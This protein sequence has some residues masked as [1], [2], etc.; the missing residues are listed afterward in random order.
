MSL[1]SLDLP[2]LQPCVD[3]SFWI[4]W[5]P[6]SPINWTLAWLKTF[7]PTIQWAMSFA[8]FHP[9]V[10]SSLEKETHAYGG[11]TATNGFNCKFVSNHTISPKLMKLAQHRIHTAIPKS[12][13]KS[14][15]FHPDHS[16]P[17]QWCLQHFVK[18][19]VH[20]CDPL[21]PDLCFQF[22]QWD[23]GTGN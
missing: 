22:L 20:L 12:L 15:L 8:L 10:W 2:H 19:I 1:S 16:C 14:H 7:C 9:L 17:V 18:I 5:L 13:A 3:A 4:E 6:N 11:T 23:D 21:L